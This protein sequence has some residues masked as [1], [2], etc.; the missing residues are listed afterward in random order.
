MTLGNVNQKKDIINMYGTYTRYEKN[1]YDINTC[2]NS[3]I[4]VIFKN[5]IKNGSRSI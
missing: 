5:N 1:L 4:S 3:F 2:D